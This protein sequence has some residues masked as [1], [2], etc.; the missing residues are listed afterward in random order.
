MLIDHGWTV[1]KL[2]QT[3]HNG[4]PDLMCL[5]QGKIFFIEVKAFD[6]KLSPLQ[7]FRHKQLQAQGF[8]VFTI[9]QLKNVQSIAIAE[10]GPILP[11]T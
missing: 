1:V 6:G 8:N 10:S 7:K 4:M 5:K 9:N 11:P 2:I 3:N